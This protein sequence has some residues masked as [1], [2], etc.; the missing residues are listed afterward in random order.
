MG[1]DNEAGNSNLLLYLIYPFI[2]GV[3]VLAV[4][5]WRAGNRHSDDEERLDAIETRAWAD[6]VEDDCGQDG[7]ISVEA[8]KDLDSAHR[9]SASDDDERERMVVLSLRAVDALRSV[10]CDQ[11][12]NPSLEATPES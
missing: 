3:V 9:L 7:F 8:R 6:K 1:G 10:G 12:V 5:E 2:I 4:T 11:V